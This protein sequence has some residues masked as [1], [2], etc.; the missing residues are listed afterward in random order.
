MNNIKKFLH[1]NADFGYAN[2]SKK[3]IFSK[4]PILG[5]RIPVLRK[6]AKE[7]EPEYIELE[8]PTL[9]HEEI[10]LYG[11]SASEIKDENEQLE[12]LKNLLPFFDNWATC[13]LVVGSMK[14]L[15]GEKS[16]KFFTHLVT[17]NNEYSIRVG[18][19]G[20]MKFFIKSDKILEILQNIRK[21]QNNAYYVKMATAWFYAEL[22]T[23]NFDFARTE[24]KNC[25]DLFIKNKAISKANESFRVTA[26]QKKLLNDLK[27][28]SC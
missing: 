16:Y 23:V 5:V 21:I 24:I 8:Q 13:D 7:L 27:T 28:K 18:I 25:Q 17:S 3:T 9:S 4:Y 15:C 20:L 12:Y 6:F 10:L 19:V 14:S 26:Q 1:D 22:C 2:F 11:F